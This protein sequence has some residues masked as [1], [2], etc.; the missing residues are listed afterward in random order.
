M[1]RYDSATRWFGTI[2]LG[3]L[4]SGSRLCAAQ[5]PIVVDSASS[6]VGYF[7][8]IGFQSEYQLVSSTGFRFA[9]R[10]LSGLTLQPAENRLLLTDVLFESTDCSGQ[11]YASIQNNSVAGGFI[12]R[13]TFSGVWYVPKSATSEVQRSFQSKLGVLGACTSTSGTNFSMPV[14]L[15]D[16]SVTGVTPDT[17]LPPLTLA[18]IGTPRLFEDG[19]ETLPTSGQARSLGT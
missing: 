1:P 15:N 3:F 19:F 9:V 10:A 7:T 13:S 2:C 5:A 6:F 18:A 4:I 12:F 16:P 17:Y 11:A 8:S 14:F